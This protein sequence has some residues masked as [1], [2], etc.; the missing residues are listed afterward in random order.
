MPNPMYQN[1]WRLLLVRIESKTSQKLWDK[2]ELKQLML[3]CMIDAE[4]D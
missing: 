2:N 1:A 3:Q 4:E